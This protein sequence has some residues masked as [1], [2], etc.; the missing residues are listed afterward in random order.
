MNAKT[1]DEWRARLREIASVSL[2]DK[3]RFARRG[4]LAGFLLFAA[5]SIFVT[6]FLGVFGGGVGDGWDL[7]WTAAMMTFVLGGL[8]GLSLRALFMRDVHQLEALIDKG[9]STR[10]AITS[11]TFAPESP[12]GGAS[13]MTVTWQEEGRE[14]SARMNDRGGVLKGPIARE[15]VVITHGRRRWVGVVVGDNL[16]LALRPPRE[17]HL[18]GEKNA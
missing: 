6:V 12:L 3:R 9:S 18:F 14:V 7:F 4:G 13:N 1:E 15:V 2:D 8:L 10:G 11:R 5:L 16:L 17:Y